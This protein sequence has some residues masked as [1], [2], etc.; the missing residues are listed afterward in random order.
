MKMNFMKDRSIILGLSGLAC[1][2]LSPT[3]QAVVP[4]PDGGYPGFN[5]AEGQNA[6]FS[7]TTGVWNTAIGAYSLFNDS[8]G[9]GN[10]AAGINGLR[11]NV[12]GSFNPFWALAS[13]P[14]AQ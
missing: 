11:I 4:A 7:L 12:N 5:T 3:A 13:L 9:R 10:T 14:F 6:L 2:A 8:T 1:F